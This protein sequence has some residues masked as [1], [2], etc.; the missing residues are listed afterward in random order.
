MSFEQ[1]TPDVI[2][3]SVEKACG[4]KLTGLT[5]ALPSY[6]NR[7][8]ELRAEDGAKLIVKFYRPGRWTLQAVQ[9]EHRFVLDCQEA[10][11][12]VVPALP[13]KNGSTIG[14]NDGI[15]FAVYPRRA[16][17]QFEINSDGDW[18]RLGS[19]VARMH[20]CGEKRNA[21]GRILMH[22]RM[23]TK[24]DVDHLCGAVI[25]EKF[26]GAYGAAAGQLIDAAA[27]LFDGLERIRI[28]GDCHRGN[29]LDRLE[30]GLLLIDFDDMAMGPPVQDLWLLLPDRAAKSSRE[31]GLFLSGYERFRKFDRA[32]VRCIEALRAMRMIYFLSWC[33][34]QVDDF[35]FKRNFPDW[36]SDRFWQ[37]EINDLREQ[38]GLVIDK[39]ESSGRD[40][41]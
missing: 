38:V 17:R 23:S 10:E 37:T 15:L 18:S 20:L 21:G 26:R 31:I 35:Q 41:L 5:I 30:Q 12:P 9:D 2:L 19:L 29:I 3:S 33:S 28:H 11:L 22:P 25:P 14:E 6:I 7:V 16:G 4:I 13:L 24:A 36:G 40:Y 34:R 8:Y 1:L 27:P 32:S 39:M